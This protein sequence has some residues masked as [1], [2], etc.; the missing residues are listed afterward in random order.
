MDTAGFPIDVQWTDIDA[1]SSALDFTYDE[2]NF[3]DLPNLVRRLQANG[4]HYVN[5]I[6]PG[7]NSVQPTGT[8]F[9]FDDGINKNVFM[10]KFNS[11]E[12]INGKVRRVLFH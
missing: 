8:Y 2:I 10:T 1:M 11:T 5:I 12:I 6:D 3:R 9:P 7:I 4:M